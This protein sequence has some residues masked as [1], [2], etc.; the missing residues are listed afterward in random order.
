MSKFVEKVIWD[1]DFFNMNI[2]KIIIRI[3]NQRQIELLNEI[4]KKNSINLYYYILDSKYKENIKLLEFNRFYL[5]QCKARFELNLCDY[6]NNE[7]YKK[8][9]K[10]TIF[11]DCKFNIKDLYKLSKQVYKKSRFYNDNN[12]N[13]NKVKDL[14]ELWVYN[15]YYKGFAD[16]IYIYVDNNEIYGFCI[17]K[18][19]AKDILRVSLICVDKEQRGKRIASNMLYKIINDYKKKNYKKC[20][21]SPQSSNINALNFYIRNGFKFYKSEFIFHKWNNKKGDSSH[22]NSF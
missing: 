5:V 16:N 21:S 6:K 2:Y 8:N 17:I 14:Y 1:S 4:M 11:N 12:I 15:S 22:E 13:K 19:E 20:L 10:V 18:N 3:N 7:L 9:N